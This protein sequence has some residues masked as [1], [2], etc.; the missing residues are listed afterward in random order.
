MGERKNELET[1]NSCSPADSKV[2][3]QHRKGK[4]QHSTQLTNNN[5]VL[6][7]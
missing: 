3:I 6:G 5:N 1:Q 4:K 7:I 2:R